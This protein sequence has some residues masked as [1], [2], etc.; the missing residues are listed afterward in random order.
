MKLPEGEEGELLR[1]ALAHEFYSAK[2]CFNSF[3]EMFAANMKRPEDKELSIKI[4]N[5]YAG[6]LAHLYEFNMK[7][8]KYDSRFKSMEIDEVLNNEARKHLKIRRERILG[9]RGAGLNDISYYQVEV[10]S[11]F[12]MDWLIMRN[13]HYHVDFKRASK[14]E[15]ITLTKFYKK[16]HR[17]VFLMYEYMIE[18]WGVDN[19]DNFYMGEIEEFGRAI[20]E[21]K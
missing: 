9:G 18:L 16:Y 3:C 11:E 17:F 12:G 4:Y 2:N 8:I 1:I 5:S 14:E 7:G 21:N 20:F 15:D 6:F 10:P 19:F 13:R